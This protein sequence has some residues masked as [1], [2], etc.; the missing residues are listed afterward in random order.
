MDQVNASKRLRSI[1][2]L[3]HQGLV[4]EG[5]SL[6]PE[7]A[8][9]RSTIRRAE[10]AE[11]G[12]VKP[13]AK[14][15][16]VRIF[17][18]ALRNAKLDPSSAEIATGLIRCLRGEGLQEHSNLYFFREAVELPFVLGLTVLKD[19]PT[20]RKWFASL[21]KTPS[22]F[23]T[24]EL[25]VRK[26]LGCVDQEPP[27][28]TPEI[29]DAGLRPDTK[30]MVTSADMA[31]V[32]EATAEI[33]HWCGSL[34]RFDLKKDA[35][36]PDEDAIFSVGHSVHVLNSLGIRTSIGLLRV[37]RTEY[38]LNSWDIPQWDDH[39]HWL[40]GVTYGVEPIRS[41]QI[42][43]QDREEERYLIGDG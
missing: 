11:G 17:I 24:M 40:M 13:R 22:H 35:L 36:D 1:L 33:R 39:D 15:E 21:P 3:S 8:I 18:S 32:R 14:L 42:W 12:W 7:A 37:S 9:S 25:R 10:G 23:D 41:I 27:S 5:K 28:H 43:F 34:L 6:K 20:L 30:Y 2:C 26:A 31:A 29:I 4:R 38:G 16:L 19:F